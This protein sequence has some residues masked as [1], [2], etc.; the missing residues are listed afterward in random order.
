MT[1]QINGFQVHIA[2]DEDK[3]FAD[4]TSAITALANQCITQHGIFSI[5]LAGGNTPR[6]LYS[7][8]ARLPEGVFPWN[9]TYLFLGDE[10]CVAHDNGDSNY[11]MIS[12]S[13]LSRISIPSTNVFPTINQQKDPVE[14]ARRYE[15]AIRRFFKLEDG[16]HQG[17]G[18]GGSGWPRFSLVLLGLGGDGHTAS[19]FPGSPALSED[20]R[21]F[22]ANQFEDAATNRTI[23]R[24]TLTKNVI[25]SAY[26]V[27]FLV[28]GENKATVLEEIFTRP[29]LSLPAQ[30][31]ANLCK[32][33]A[34]EWFLD[35]P[36]AALI[37]K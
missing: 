11:K 24:L 29:E 33:E 37:K 5:A 9:K 8:L 10:R 15:Q 36:A 3:L 28:A 22:V 31:V 7:N 6:G 18:S 32:R 16:D 26:K 20:K 14:S 23:E 35:K 4:L 17:V 12:E 34:V 13:L 30:L 27:F 1:E 19:L 21:F 25:A 2:D